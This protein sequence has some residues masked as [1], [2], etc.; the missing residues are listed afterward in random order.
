MAKRRNV[1]RLPGSFPLTQRMTVLRSEKWKVGPP[2][3]E[4]ATGLQPNSN[5]LQLGAS[6]VKVLTR[7][8]TLVRRQVR[9]KRLGIDFRRGAAWDT[10]KAIWMDGKHWLLKA[11]HDN[12]TKEA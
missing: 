10:P 5:S 1:I 9:A 11:P 6:K 12:G 7:V 3:S 4:I 2:S 8:F